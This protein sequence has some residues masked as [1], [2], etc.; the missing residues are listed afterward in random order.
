MRSDERA[1]N[2]ACALSALSWSVLPW[3]HAPL[4]HNANPVRV[5]ITVLHLL[6]AGLFAVRGAQRTAA[7]LWALLKTLPSALIALPAFKLAG[8]PH[9]WSTTPTLI[10]TLAGA[11]TFW[12]LGTLGR[13]F[14][15]FPG[16][17]A[18][19][20]HGPYRVVRHP[21]YLGEMI[22]VGACGGAAF[23]PWGALGVVATALVLAPRILAEEQLLEGLPEHEAFC[24]QTPWRLVPG[25]W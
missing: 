21:A 9:L 18:L 6:M 16:A 15:V 20:T 7:D 19:V 25:V 14:A 11:W 3:F 5:T 13:S 12:S 17:R 24:T 4:E 8:P 10:F 1:F 2:I 23:G 22:M